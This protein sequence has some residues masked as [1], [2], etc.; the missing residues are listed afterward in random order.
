MGGLLPMRSARL[1]VIDTVSLLYR[2]HPQRYLQCRPAEK[3]N[4]G[5]GDKQ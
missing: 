5:A 4:A 3:S 1:D 2:L